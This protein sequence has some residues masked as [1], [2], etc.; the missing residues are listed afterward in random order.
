LTQRWSEGRLNVDDMLAYSAI[1]GTGL[2]TIPLPGDVT[3]EQLEKMIGDMATLAVKLHKPLSARLLPVSGKK[4]G[5]RT[6]FDNP[7]LG[8]ATLQPLP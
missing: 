7:F 2:D 4:A 8:N 5:D 1:C 3:Q 6:E